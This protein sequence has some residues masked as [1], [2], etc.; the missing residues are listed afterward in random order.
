MVRHAR[1]I[2]RLAGKDREPHKEPQ[3]VHDGHDLAGQAAPGPIPWL[4]SPPCVRRLLVSLD[5]RAGSEHVPEVEPVRQG[6][7]D[8][9]EG[10]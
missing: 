5:G 3:R 8:T 10:A 9:P 1:E 6:V 2:V 7:E 4:R